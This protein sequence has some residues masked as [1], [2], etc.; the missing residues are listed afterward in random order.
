MG[1]QVYWM[2]G[3]WQGYGV[4]S[5]CDYTGC[6]HKID[7]GMGYAHPGAV[8]DNNVFCCSKHEQIDVESFDVNY[9]REHPEWL[10]HIL[11]DETWKQ[12]REEEPEIVEKYKKLL[13]KQE[14]KS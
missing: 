9:E 1:Y 8:D 10:T 6:M 4:P 7:R 2:Y 14:K 5:Y 12:W 3:R 13:S 11:S